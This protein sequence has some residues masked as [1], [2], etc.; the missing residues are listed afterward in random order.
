[1]LPGPCPR[2]LVGK[3]GLK[4]HIYVQG[5]LGRGV[6]EVEMFRGEEGDGLII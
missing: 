4:R 1:M 3:K 6:R 2:T 5:L